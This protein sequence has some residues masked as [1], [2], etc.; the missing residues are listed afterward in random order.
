MPRLAD[1]MESLT[2]EQDK[3]VMMGSIKTSKDQALI[4]GDSKVDSKSKK[5]AKKPPEQKSLQ[6]TVSGGATRFQEE[7]PEE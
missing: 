4:A 2:Q 6:E 7:L 1:F 5:K 3:M